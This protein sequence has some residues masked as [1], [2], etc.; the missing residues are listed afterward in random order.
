MAEAVKRQRADHAHLPS[1]AAVDYPECGS[2]V[3]KR[4]ELPAAKVDWLLASFGGCV[5]MGGQPVAA[6]GAPQAPP[7]PTPPTRA[8]SP[9][10]HI[11]DAGARRRRPSARCKLRS[12]CSTVTV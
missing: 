11:S 10:A 4:N 6:P 5:R 2:L 9:P 1:V 3:L 7:P 12:S 8:R